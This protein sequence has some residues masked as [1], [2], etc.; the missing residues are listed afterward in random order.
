[1]IAWTLERIARAVGG[2]VVGEDAAVRGV[3]IDSRSIT[4][5]S[6]FV[7]IAGERFDGH[8]FVE[9]AFKS[10]A[11]GALVAREISTGPCVIVDDTVRALGELA[12]AYRHTLGGA[13]IGVTGSC[14]KT[15]TCRLLDAAMGGALTGTSSVKSFNNA[16]GLPLT[17]L[18]AR[19][20][21]AFLVCEMGTSSP[22]EIARLAEIARPDIGIITSIGRAHL[23]GL[24]DLDGVRREKA[25]VAGP[26]TLIPSGD[27][28]L[29]R[30][31]APGVRVESVAPSDVG[32]SEGRT[33]FTF[34]GETYRVP[35]VG[36][37][38]AQNASFA[39]RVALELGVS[40]AAIRAGL[41]H[42]EAPAMRFESHSIGG[43]T[44]VN[45][46]YNAN[47]E[48]MAA[49]LRAFAAA[50]GS[51][52]RRVL[53]LGDMLE[54]GGDAP[55]AHAE[56]AALL[57]ELR[58]HAVVGIGPEMSAALGTRAALALDELDAQRVTGL[59]EDG[60]AVLLKG[61]RGIGLE[62][63]LDAWRERCVEGARA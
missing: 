40:P 36:A 28:A 37:H 51:S 53:V 29:R 16:I 45:D 33:A 56:I 59:F 6:L 57:D 44:L 31:I 14:G 22:G 30:C 3:S 32:V 24:G 38:H 9:S 21:D 11:A 55:A 13:V 60:D 20:D 61:S 52:R 25:C 1:M 18:S 17:I 5:G 8:G 58:P 43:V 48:S 54:L 62:R 19:E 63:V 39:V 27:D 49:S 7:A 23:A 47:P 35:L 42:A 46:A 41:A 4:P 15:T 34:L 26:L 50:H 12:A 10:G 2:R